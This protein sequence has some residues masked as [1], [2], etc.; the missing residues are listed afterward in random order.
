MCGVRLNYRYRWRYTCCTMDGTIEGI[1]EANVLDEEI[2]DV[3]W[4]CSCRFRR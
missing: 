2:A 3:V 4:I 1:A